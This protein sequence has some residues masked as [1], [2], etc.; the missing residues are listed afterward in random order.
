ML[1]AWPFDANNKTFLVKGYV[2][3]CALFVVHPSTD[4]G[5]CCNQVCVCDFKG[6]SR[7]ELDQYLGDNCECGTARDVCVDPNNVSGS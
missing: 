7:E 4:R 2:G 6:N 3:M 5:D 1:L